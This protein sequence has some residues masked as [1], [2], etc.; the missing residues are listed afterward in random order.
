M[1]QDTEVLLARGEAA[2]PKRSGCFAWQERIAVSM[3][4][5]PPCAV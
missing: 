3:R 5:R 2:L 1:A 4:R